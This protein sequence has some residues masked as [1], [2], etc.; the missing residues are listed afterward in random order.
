[1]VEQMTNAAA[2]RAML[3]V[4]VNYERIADRAEVRGR[5]N[6]MLGRQDCVSALVTTR[7]AVDGPRRLAGRAAHRRRGAK[8]EAPAPEREGAERSGISR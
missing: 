4:A 5:L 7:G 8:D 1:M 3:S 6:E 2:K